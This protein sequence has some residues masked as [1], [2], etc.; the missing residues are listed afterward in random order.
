[1]KN[2]ICLFDMDGTLTP[3]RKKIEKR[4]ISKLK[5]LS[6]Y[7]KI[8]IVTGSDFDYVMQQCSEIF[9]I[10]G[11]PVD[12][13]DIFPCNGTKHYTWKN[14][15]FVL[16]HDAEM[17]A[18]IGQQNYNYLLQSLTAF[19]MM[20]TLSHQLPYTGTFF[21]YRGSMLNWCPIG[22]QAG[23]LER[24]AWEKADSEKMIREYF[25]DE[26]KTLIADKELGITVALGGSTSFDI[27]PD[28][29]DKT[30]VMNHLSEF[31]KIYFVGDRCDE[32]G[33][34]KALYDLLQIDGTS[35]KSEGP[36]DTEI[37]IENIIKD[38]S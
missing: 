18:T 37:V 38:L 12:R 13:I 15:K 28:G 7:A 6:E 29:W 24:S 5:K 2:N 20:I 23:D 10:G 9:D 4:T 26:I 16:V 32:G 30:Y 21:Q 27:Y 14:S 8:G 11:V 31:Q 1:M 33:N 17:I 35:F 34:D 3:P 25:F 36:D 19:Q 22:R